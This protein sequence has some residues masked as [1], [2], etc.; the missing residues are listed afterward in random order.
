MAR[1]RIHL[2]PAE[3][4]AKGWLCCKDLKA[5]HR[6]MPGLRTRP[7]GSVWQGQGA[8]D[9]Y[10]PAECVPWRW[11]PGPAQLRRQSVAKQAQDL[12]GGDCLTLDTETTGVGHDDEVCEITII[13]V[14]GA[15]ILDT[16][17]KPTRPISDE[18]SAY[19]GIT[20]AMLAS[21]PSWPEV[22]EQYAAAV[23]GRTVVAYNTAFDVRL[24]RQTHQL[25]GLT[26]P[27]LTT[28]CAMLMYAE[29]HGEYDRGR[30]R[31][32]WLKL[33]DAATDCGVAEDGAHRALADA[34]MTLGL[35]RY[36][37]R[38]TNGRRPPRPKVATVLQETLPPVLDSNSA[39]LPRR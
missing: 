14:T 19:N 31:W 5:R 3:A 20:N 39:P 22:A 13:D 4:E 7:A 12:I 35:L 8:Y 21:A 18:T 16:L 36:L 11:E 27:V 30:D 2:T 24:L 6:L 26:A 25:H 28:A 37:Q 32:R 34:R 38:Y 33:I 23:E 15:P 9:V 10:D 1:T 17:V 29:W